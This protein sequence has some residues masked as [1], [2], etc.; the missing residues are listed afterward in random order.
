MYKTSIFIFLLGIISSC[1]ES[2]DSLPV[3]EN[4][5][6]MTEDEDAPKYSSKINY[7]EGTGWG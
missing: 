5:N 2:T 4:N 1:S 7:I 3:E 6:V